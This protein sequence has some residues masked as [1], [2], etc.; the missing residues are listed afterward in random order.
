MCKELGYEFHY[1]SIYSLV[2][3]IE[4]SLHT[5]S[6]IKIEGLTF[7]PILD[8]TSL[9]LKTIDINKIGL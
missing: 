1:H 9:V 5:L 7:I 6:I 2:K 3:L 4:D 8:L